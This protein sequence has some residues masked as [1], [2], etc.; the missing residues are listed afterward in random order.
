MDRITCTL[1]P[2]LVDKLDAVSRIIPCSRSSLISLMLSENIS[3]IEKLCF[4][5]RDVNS[6]DV[7]VR[8]ASGQSVAKIEERYR[9][10]LDGFEMYQQN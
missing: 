8:R 3:L 9:E 4:E 10:I 7:I 5:I 6:N 1:P 2:E